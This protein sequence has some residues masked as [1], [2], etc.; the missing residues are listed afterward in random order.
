MNTSSPLRR[1]SRPFLA[2]LVLATVTVGA[3]LLFLSEPSPVSADAGGWPTAT[4]TLVI[5]TS[6]PTLPAYPYPPA[7]LVSPQ[8]SSPLLLFPP[9][10]TYTP[11]VPALVQELAVPDV[12]VALN[13]PAPASARLTWITCV[14]F[15][16]VGLAIAI[17]GTMALRSRIRQGIR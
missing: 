3:A 1:S 9:T 5:W 10:P 4:P 13:P 16:L 6:T 8:P 12:Q 15:A 7:F 2:L 17:A 14:P 11:V